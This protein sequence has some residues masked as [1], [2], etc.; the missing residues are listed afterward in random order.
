MIMYDISLILQCQVSTTVMD[1]I[2]VFYT[3]SCLYLCLRCFVAVS[4]PV[5]KDLYKVAQRGKGG[6]VGT[7]R[8][9]DG[10][11]GEVVPQAP[12]ERKSRRRCFCDTERL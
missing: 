3:V 6:G 10:T 9:R 8:R 5:N 2:V 12:V 1:L 4:L 11:G 7:G